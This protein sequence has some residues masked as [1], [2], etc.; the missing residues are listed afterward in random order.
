VQLGRPKLRD[1][2]HGA[3]ATLLMLPATA[4]AQSDPAN[5]IDATSLFYTEQGRT[6]I[7]EPV[8]KF[9]HLFPDAQSISAQFGIDVMTGAS[10]TGAVPSGIVQTHTS[11]SGH[12]ITSAAGAIPTSPFQDRRAS[13][14]LDW[15]RPWGRY[16]TSTIGTHFSREKDYQS[17]GANGTISFDAV[18]RLFTITIGGGIS[19]DSVFPVGGITAGLS[20]SIASIAS[21][22]PKNV[23]NLLFGVSH[24]MSRRWMLSVNGTRT[25][26]SGYLTEPYKVVSVLGS[27]GAPIGSLTEKRPSTRNRSSVM[28]SSVY[29]F[30]N[31]ILYSSYR[32]Y[33][34]SWGIRSHTVDLKYRHDLGDD[35]YLEPLVRFYRQSAADFYTAGVISGN[36]FPD[37]A[38]ADYRLGTLNTITVGGTYGFHLGE[39][40]GL[41]TI[42]AQ[43]IRQAGN[44]S[45]PNA[46]GIQRRFD[47]S[48][49]LNIG[50]LVIGYSF[51]Y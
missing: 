9:T 45:P 50:A 48:P 6:Q 20:P 36:P 49:P 5:Q 47:L 41:W 17:L 32:Y 46:I 33:W 31:D 8:I 29:H 12:V 19:R 38:S 13:L 25:S 10:P 18:R 26:E 42:R 14:D 2:L 43:Y 22:S 1:V 44:S 37:F 3:A 24:I 40:P 34:D 27:T 15:K 16:A 35:G 30:T 39:T 7:V 51:G 21:S 11:P 23:N 4:K 28:L